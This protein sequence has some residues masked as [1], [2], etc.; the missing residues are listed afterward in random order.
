MGTEHTDGPPP[1]Y[2]DLPMPKV[3]YRR[4]AQP[5]RG[6]RQLSDEEQA[7]VDEI[8]LAEAEIGKLWA[9]IYNRRTTTNA[10]RYSLR[11]E[12]L[13]RDAFMNLVR[14]VTLPLDPYREALDEVEK[15][16]EGRDDG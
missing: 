15:M 10:L 5:L 11:A 7:L 14:S 9:R 8:K 16:T 13:F 6:Y 2:G 12:G 4:E 1:G 3:P